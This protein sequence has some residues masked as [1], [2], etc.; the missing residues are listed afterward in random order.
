MSVL[1]LL[2]GGKSEAEE[3]QPGLMDVIEKQLREDNWYYTKSPDYPNQIDVPM[4]GI[5]ARFACYFR[6]NPEQEIIA[7]YVDISS[8]APE[9]RRKEAMEYI[10]RINHNLYLGNYEMNM[11]TGDIRYKLSMDVEGGTVSTTMIKNMMITGINMADRCNNSL[12]E[13]MF[14]HAIPAAAAREAMS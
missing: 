1:E 4:N 11:E 5:N 12:M 14:S 2:P 3:K 9:G 6:V 8:K 7:F 10:T 13:V